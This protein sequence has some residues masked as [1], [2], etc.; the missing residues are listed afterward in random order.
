MEEK[1]WDWERYPHTFSPK[2]KGDTECGVAVENIRDGVSD[3]HVCKLR[4][5][6]HP[7]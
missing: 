4:R 5:E 1:Q 7:I 6:Q 3:L 2:K